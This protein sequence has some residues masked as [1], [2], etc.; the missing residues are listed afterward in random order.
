MSPGDLLIPTDFIYLTHF[1]EGRK[2]PHQRKHNFTLRNS[3]KPRKIPF[4]ENA[5]SYLLYILIY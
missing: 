1:I 4:L 2:P 3:L 5:L